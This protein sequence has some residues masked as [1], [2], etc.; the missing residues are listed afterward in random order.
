MFDS[1]IVPEPV[2]DPKLPG[3]RKFWLRN[4]RGIMLICW[5]Y[6][7]VS[8]AHAIYNMFRTK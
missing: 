2:I 8:S 6:I 3:Y 7:W 5:L 1:V 4:K